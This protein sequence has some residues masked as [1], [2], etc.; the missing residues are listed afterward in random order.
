MQT[1]LL[2]RELWHT[3]ESWW[4]GRLGDTGCPLLRAIWGTHP[5]L[6]PLPTSR[7]SCSSGVGALQ[8]ASQIASGWCSPFCQDEEEAGSTSPSRASFP[9]S[10]VSRAWTATRP[11]PCQATG[12]SLI[13]F[14]ARKSSFPRDG[15]PSG[16]AFF[17]R[18]ASLTCS[19]HSGLGVGM[20]G[21]HSNRGFQTVGHGVEQA[22][23]VCAA[24][25]TAFR[26]PIP[27]LAMRVPSSIQTAFFLSCPGACLQSSDPISSSVW[28]CKKV[29]GHM[30]TGPGLALCGSTWPRSPHSVPLRGRV[31]RCGGPGPLEKVAVEGKASH[32]SSCPRG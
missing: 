7:V 21:G 25:K 26:I 27:W 5:G 15:V 11:P 30:C 29:E 13:L 1:S 22:G 17:C 31:G 24:G 20:E 4:P 6:T 10:M 14:M 28:G 23:E 18:P 2:H 3:K 9:S 16:T 12:K 32:S 19:H 8:A